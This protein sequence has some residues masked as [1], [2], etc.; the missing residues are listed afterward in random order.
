MGVETE[1]QTGW[2]GAEQEQN[3]KERQNDSWLLSLGRARTWREGVEQE[4]NRKQR[5]TDPRQA[6]T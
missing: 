6:R 3:E 1:K 2:D 4:Q 5:Q